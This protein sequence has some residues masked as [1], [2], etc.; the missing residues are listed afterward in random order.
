MNLAYL[1]VASEKMGANTSEF[2]KSFCHIKICRNIAFQL[3][4]GAMS[5]EIE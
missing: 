5:S 2:E 1:L 3:K 4:P